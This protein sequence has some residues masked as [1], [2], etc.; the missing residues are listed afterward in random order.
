[1][2]R[3]KRIVAASLAAV[4]LLAACSE[5]DPEASAE[6]IEAI[7]EPQPDVDDSGPEPVEEEAAPPLEPDPE[8]EVEP[9]PTEIDITVVPDEITEEYVEAVLVELEGLY[10]EAYILFQE[11]DEATIDVTDRLGAAFTESEYRAR[12]RQFT[13]IAEAGY[14]GYQRLGAAAPRTHEVQRILDSSATCV[15]A[16]TLLD[17]SGVRVDAGAPQA[18][19]V[20]LGPPDLEPFEQLN[21]TPWV[22]HEFPSGELGELL[23]SRPCG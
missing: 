22:V 23:E 1:M 3:H 4:L 14:P 2:E 6:G 12:L 15:Y 19:F 18:S 16:E 13:D 8:P 9:G 17:V 7:E 5:A 10:S 11:A 21:P 20:E